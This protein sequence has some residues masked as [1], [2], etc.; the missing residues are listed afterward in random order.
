MSKSSSPPASNPRPGSS[1]APEKCPVCGQPIEYEPVANRDG[2][3]QAFC[4][5]T[6]SGPVVMTAADLAA[7]TQKEEPYVSH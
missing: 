7:D 5:C 4:P 3:S 1:P 2:W 6:P